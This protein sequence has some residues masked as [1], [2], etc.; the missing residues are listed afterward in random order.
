MPVDCPITCNTCPG[1]CEN[2]YSNCDDLI[3]ECTTNPTMPVDCPI[4]CNTCQDMSSRYLVKS[5]VDEID[6]TKYGCCS[7]FHVIACAKFWAI[8]DIAL[9]IIGI[10]LA[11]FYKPPP[12]IDTQPASN[13]STIFD[14]GSSIYLSSYIFQRVISIVLSALILYG[15]D[16]VKPQMLLPFLGISGFFFVVSVIICVI[17]AIGILIHIIIQHQYLFIIAI[18]VGLLMLGIFFYTWYLF[19]DLY[20]RAY[21]YLKEVQEGKKNDRYPMK[22]ISSA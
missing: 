21:K 15:I 16:K 20:Y 7:S 8:L 5:N 18:L 11:L 13:S 2:R 12:H 14:T 10:I 22:N 17:G 4:T 1:S 9:S 19:L 3:D 6:E